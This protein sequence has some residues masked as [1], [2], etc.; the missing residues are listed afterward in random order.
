MNGQIVEISC[1]NA[2]SRHIKADMEGNLVTACRN[3]YQ[4]G[5]LGD[6]VVTL[7]ALYWLVIDSGLESNGA[8]VN[9]IVITLDIQ[10]QAERKLCCL[11]IRNGDMK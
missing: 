10:H 9:F 3:R 6:S 7:I 8:S 1:D 5:S 4:H 2:A 11:P